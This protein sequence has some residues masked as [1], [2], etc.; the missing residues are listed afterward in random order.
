[1]RQ[2]GSPRER[3]ALESFAPADALRTSAC[4]HAP[5]PMSILSLEPHDAHVHYRASDTLTDAAWAR[6]VD[7]LSR[8]ERDRADR[9]AVE[10]DR[11]SFVVAHALLRQVL[12]AYT[13]IAMEALEFTVDPSGK[14]RVANP[15]HRSLEFNLTHAHGLAACAVSRLPVGVD[16]ESIAR[17]VEPLDLA[18]RYFSAAELAH[19]EA[20]PPPERATRFIEMWTLKEAYVKALGTGLSLPLWSFTIRL[21]TPS[22]AFEPPDSQASPCRFALFAPSPQHRIA[23]AVLAGG[24]APRISAWELSDITLSGEKAAGLSPVAQGG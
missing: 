4:P 20:C 13:G 21:E 15:S 17:R 22:I 6:A 16:A 11:R 3:T 24:S 1:M 10:R 19:L 12:A 2:A 7:M 8:V 14:P 18:A 23:V 5:L 9:F